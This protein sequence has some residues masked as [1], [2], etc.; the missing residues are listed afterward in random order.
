MNVVM[1]VFIGLFGLKIVW[2]LLTPYVMTWQRASSDEVESS[3]ISLMPAVE[4]ILY[5]LIL[6]F[7]FFIESET[8]HGD[9]ATLA[10]WGMLIIVGS[11]IHLLLAGVLAG[12]LVARFMRNDS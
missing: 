10:I 5:F 3:G 11:Y 7:S 6:G 12:A 8:W 1:L 2:N 4:I 9:T